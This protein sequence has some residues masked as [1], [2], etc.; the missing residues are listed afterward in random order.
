MR[1]VSRVFSHGQAACIVRSTTLG[2]HDPFG[3]GVMRASNFVSPKK[4]AIT[5]V[6]KRTGERI[7]F[8][9]L[10][11]VFS[12]LRWQ[13]ELYCFRSFCSVISA[14]L[15]ALSGGALIFSA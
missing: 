13:P 9:D 4:P 10:P 11:N 1:K 2:P 14:P 12:H 6:Q 15:D 5:A 7:T 8:L 3:S